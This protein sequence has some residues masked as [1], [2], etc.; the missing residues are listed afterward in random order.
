MPFCVL[1]GL[2]MQVGVESLVFAR[3]NRPIVVLP[4]RFND[5]AFLFW[6]R[7]HLLPHTFLI[8][9]VRGLE[10]ASRLRRL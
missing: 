9:A 4:E 8:S 5:I 3:K 6:R 10:V 7:A 2:F 1:T